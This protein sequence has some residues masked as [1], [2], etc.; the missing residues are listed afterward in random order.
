MR[1]QAI[2]EAIIEEDFAAL[3]VLSTMSAGVVD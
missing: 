3:K 2:H 1:I